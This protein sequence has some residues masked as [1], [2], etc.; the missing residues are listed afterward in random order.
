MAATSLIEA[1]VDVDFPTVYR[2]EAGLDSI[3]QA[4]G[5]CNREGKRPLEESIVYIYQPEGRVPPRIQP[6]VSIY[7]NEI[8]PN[9]VDSASPEAI[10]AY[11]DA[12]CTGDWG[13]G[14]R[15]WG[16]SCSLYGNSAFLRKTFP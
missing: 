6:N 4:A 13:I 9:F 5:R 1:G 3:I 14:T 16:N 12:L 11:F 8:Q 2:A 10:Q 15:I 7:K